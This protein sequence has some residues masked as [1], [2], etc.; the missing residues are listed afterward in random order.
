MK[1]KLQNSFQLNPKLTWMTVSKWLHNPSRIHLT[2]NECK[3]YLDVSWII[4]N[5]GG[6]FITDVKENLLD[7]E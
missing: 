2:F 1:R 5:S 3:K 7:Q 6:K 4:R